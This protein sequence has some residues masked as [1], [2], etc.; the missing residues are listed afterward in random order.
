MASGAAK[1]FAGMG[2][3]IRMR[4]SGA[5]PS[6]LDMAGGTVLMDR[7]PPQVNDHVGNLMNVSLPP[8]EKKR[9]QDGSTRQTGGSEKK[10]VEP[11]G[12]PDRRV[13]GHLGPLFHGSILEAG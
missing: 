5:R 11:T 4:R 7:P 13:F 6:P 8:A 9:S 2:S 1:F 12:L 3:D 10:V